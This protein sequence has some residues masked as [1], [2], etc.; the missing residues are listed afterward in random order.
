M[1]NFYSNIQNKER[2][3]LWNLIALAFV[4]RLVIIPFSQVL[5]ADATT[6]IF[7]SQKW[8]SNP[9]FIS[10]GVWPPIHYYFTSLSIWIFND[11]I[12]GPKVFHSLF[13]CLTISPL[14]Y[15]TRREFSQNAAW[16][17]VIIYIFSAVVLRN[18]FFALSGIPHAF[19]VASA[20]NFMSKSIHEDV[21]KHSIFAGLCMTIAS[22]FRYE[23]WL[24]IALFTGIYFLRKQWKKMIYFWLASMIFPI[25]WM[26]GNYIT[27]ND[28]F[29]GLSGAYNWNIIME[30]VNDDVQSTEVIK[31]LIYFPITWVIMISPP[32]FLLTLL[33]LIKKIF[34]RTINFKKLIWAIPFLVFL[35]V[36]IYKAY[37]G[38]LLL[39]QRFTISLV[40]LSSPLIGHLLISWKIS[41]KIKLWVYPVLLFLVPFSAIWLNFPFEKGLFFS[42]NGKQAFLE[43]RI[44]A[45]RS[46]PVIP[47]L[48]D[49]GFI[50][51][52]ELLSNNVDEKSGVIIDFISYQKI[53]FSVL[54]MKVHPN[55]IYMV[56]GAKNGSI[57][58]KELLEVIH[59]QPRGVLLL[60]CFS[61]LFNE[62][63]FHG[64]Y[65]VLKQNPNIIL[66]LETI[67]K[68]LGVGYFK[69][70]L[71]GEIKNSQKEHCLSCPEEHSLDYYLLELKNSA[72]WELLLMIKAEENNKSFQEQYEL[73]AKWLADNPPN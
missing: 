36:F 50:K 68:E 73:D 33:A 59:N 3:W 5:D 41:K 2:F 46:I 67:S 51:N 28:I 38:T 42:E 4:I 10:E 21:L 47:K 26:I 52:V 16:I 49:E 57:Y 66:K 17:S 27:H 35:V 13:A 1:T 37:H 45:Q 24:L 15:F 40:L 58:H 9:Q 14:F 31:R 39:Q 30:G 69:Y 65:L 63:E 54:N 34:S 60:S 55:Q 8:M 23:G 43:V 6:R 22:G 44:D 62:F 70:S 19:F 56:D 48:K 53:A 32:I 7:T 29:Y 18:S 64:D 12:I 72:F 71:V 25:F 20:M 61:K 11:S